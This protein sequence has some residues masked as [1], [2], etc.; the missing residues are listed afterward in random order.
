VSVEV[1]EST[2]SA[3]YHYMFDLV[4]RTTDTQQEPEVGPTS[5]AL[6]GLASE[7]SEYELFKTFF[8]TFGIVYGMYPIEAGREPKKLVLEVAQS[9]FHFDVAGKY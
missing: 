7:I 1:D 8:E 9:N 6:L 3:L 5:K 2:H 4:P